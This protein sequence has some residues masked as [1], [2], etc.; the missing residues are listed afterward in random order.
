M[1][2]QSCH[3]AKATV[4]FE[5]IVNG[6]KSEI[7]LCQ[8]CA[9]QYGLPNSGA[10]L[11]EFFGKVVSSIL[12]EA[13]A[14][15]SARRPGRK[16]RPRARCQQCGLAWADFEAHGLFG[17]AA[18]YT[19]F[20]PVIKVLLRNIH[21]RNRHTGRRPQRLKPRTGKSVAALRQEL[22]RAI[23]EQQFERAAALRDEIRAAEQA[24][25]T[26]PP[27]TP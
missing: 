24:G 13:P 11:P 9:H 25:R 15:I 1:T 2:C 12:G 7:F 19:A 27:H 8:T 21:G 22:E 16:R 26:S 20:E 10:N 4:R 18:C 3:A 17:C 23:G 14:D 6:K 5:K